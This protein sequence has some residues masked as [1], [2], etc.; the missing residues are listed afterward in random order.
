MGRRGL[1]LLVLGVGCALL[2]TGCMTIAEHASRAAFCTAGQQFSALQRVPFRQAQQATD[3]LG[4]VGTPADIDAAARAG[5]VELIDRMD[6]SS[7]AA[8]FRKRTRSM[9][10]SERDHLFAL[11]TYIQGTCSDRVPSNATK[12]AFCAV[13]K[14]YLKLQAAQF[15]TAKAGVDQLAKVGMPS[16]AD[17]GARLGF[18]E[19]IDR[20]NSSRDGADF[21]DR[22]NALTADQTSHLTALDSYI[23]L[24]C[25]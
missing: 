18:I 21:G 15:N 7:N 25:P 23:K 19:L 5:F 10:Q 16:G 8:D 22:S 24:T 20:I 4:Q 14:S 12:A 2:L 1:L 6:S 3:R 11:D 9:D 17:A 13:G